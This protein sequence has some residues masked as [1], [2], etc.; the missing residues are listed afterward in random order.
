VLRST[1]GL[2]V[3]G[4]RPTRWQP[5]QRLVSV[6]ASQDCVSRDAFGGP[7]CHMQAGVITPAVDGADMHRGG[8]G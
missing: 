7:F 4:Q 5:L 3:V 6:A 2:P 8:V 1:G